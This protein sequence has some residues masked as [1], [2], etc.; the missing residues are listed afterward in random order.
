MFPGFWSSSLDR[1]SLDMRSHSKNGWLTISIDAIS[2]AYSGQF[3]KCFT[4][5][6]YNN[7]GVID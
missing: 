1:K 7:R 5:V 6:I 3:Y 4:I 2:D